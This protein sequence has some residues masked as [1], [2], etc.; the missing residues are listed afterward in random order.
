MPHLLDAM[1]GLLCLVVAA[2]FPNLFG[3]SDAR[4]SFR[5]AIAFGPALFL[6]TGLAARSIKIWRSHRQR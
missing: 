1:I 6:L 3:L 5:S 4:A 2:V